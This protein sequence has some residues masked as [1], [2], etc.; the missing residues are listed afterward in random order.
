MGD[1]GYG[2]SSEPVAS[3]ASLGRQRCPKCRA[4]A[5]VQ[6]VVPIRAGFEYL[7]L[8]CTSCGLVF[9]AQIHTDP[10]KSDASVWVDTELS[11]RGKTGKFRGEAVPILVAERSRL[12]HLFGAN[13]RAHGVISEATMPTPKRHALTILGAFEE[14]RSELV[15]KAVILT[16]GRAG[17]VENV[18]L[19]EVHG[20]R[21]S[22][23]G[24]DGK[25]PVSTIKFTQP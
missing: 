5:T 23:R 22:I 17:T 9:D 16:D 21:V 10:P 6:N 3:T 4:L 25:W 18:W 12:V 15:G 19:D 2:V 11:R 20:L 8:R 7:T 1:L 24:H 14:A 13:T